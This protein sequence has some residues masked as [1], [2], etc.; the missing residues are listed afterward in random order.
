[1]KTLCEKQLKIRKK[2]LKEDYPCFTTDWEPVK[3]LLYGCF[4]GGGNK[5]QAC[6]GMPV[7][8][9]QKILSGAAR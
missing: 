2:Q 7:R 8:F 6:R 1:M 5:K 9:I 4:L 3:F